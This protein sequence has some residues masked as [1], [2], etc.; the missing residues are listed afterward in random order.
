MP[1]VTSN[2]GGNYRWF[3]LNT[4]NQHAAYI[5]LPYNCAVTK[6]RIIA[7]G[8]NT[9]TVATRAAIWVPYGSTLGQS[10]TFDMADGSEGTQYTYE[11]S[12]TPVV[13]N[14][15]NY[16]VGLYRN[17]SESHIFRTATGS[18]DGYTKTNT[19]GFPSIWD[20]G[21]AGTDSNDEPT[22]GAFYI[23]TP[24]VAT[25]A[26]VTR[27]SDNNIVFGWYRNASSDKPVY[28]QHVERWDNITG[29]YYAKTTDNTTHLGGGWQT[30]T[31]VTVSGNKYY[32]YRVKAWN[33]AGYSSYLYS[34]YINTTPAAPSNVVAT[35]SGGNVNITW[36]DNATNEDQFR[37]QRRESTDEGASW[38]S[39]ADMSP[40]TV[41]AGT[42]LATDTSPYVYGQYRVRAEETSQ[43]LLS[44]YVE[45]NEVVTLAAPDAPS[46]LSPDDTPFD[47]SEEQNFTWN[48]N[49]TD[50]TA[51]TKFSLVVTKSGS[52]YPKEIC[53]FTDYTD[54]TSYN[55][56]LS[57]SEEHTLGL[58]NVTR[59]SDSN[60]TAGYTAMYKSIPSLD[61]THFDDSSASGTDDLIVFSFYMSD[62]SKATSLAVKLGDDNSNCYYTD[63]NPSVDLVDGYNRLEVAKSAFSTGGTPSGWDDIT[64]L[65]VE[66]YT[67]SGA[68]SSY[69]ESI[70]FML[71]D[72]ADFSDYAGDS[73]VQFNEI[74]NVS[75]A[76]AVVADS[77]INGIDYTYKVATWGE[78]ATGSGWS[79][80]ALF[81]CV[82]R[83]QGT[84]VTSE[85]YPYSQ[86]EVEWTY[87]QAE[88]YDQVQYLCKLYDSNDILLE[89]K[90]V[91]SIIADSETGS[92]LFETTLTN[93]TTYTITLQVQEANGLWSLETELEITTEFLQ[94]TQPS[95]SLQL[96]EMEGNVSISITN[97]EVVTE[98]QNQSTQDTY[99]D[100]DSSSTN[101][102]EIGYLIA[103][104]DTGGG[105][106]IRDILLDFN[107]DSFV[108][109]T[110]VD[111]QLIL[112][113]SVTLVAGIDTKVNYIKTSWDDANVTY[114][115]IPTLDTTDYDQH[116]HSAGDSE[117]WDITDLVT[118]IADGTITDFE[119]LAVIATTTDGSIDT[120]YDSTNDELEP[121]VLIEISPENA[122]TDHNIIYRS[123]NGGDWE[124]VAD[125]VPVD[126]T[127]IDYIPNIGG[128]N[129]YYA[130]SVSLVPSVNSS[131]EVDLDISLTGTFFINGG[132]NF[133]L[134]ARLIGDNK[135]NENIG[136]NEVLKQYKGRSYPVKYQDSSLS[137]VIEFSSDC[138]I[139]TRDTIEDIINNDGNIFYRDWRGRWFYA[140]IS[141]C[142][143]EPKDPAA[144]QFSCTITRLN[145]VIE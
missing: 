12:I 88:S 136:R 49:P 25:G 115:T 21:G 104:N 120:F 50:G 41:S 142:T 89:T 94:P 116:T 140:S 111:A 20:M 77:F 130:Q 119:G 65:R 127:V 30:F 36:T 105:T 96:N 70:Y 101:Y 3:G 15:G 122:E 128:N 32:R 40:A 67:T 4:N 44:S 137:Q 92:C 24:D 143:F 60:D 10:S 58:G 69:I 109:K 61:L 42:T 126:T 100:S 106:T 91:S 110:I 112:Y 78:Y 73:F 8:Y 99:I 138:L 34:N 68:S 6:L 64:Y 27:N 123:I 72:A 124:T 121:T 23:T 17:P 54:W 144:Y 74:S 97:P 59:M 80:E 83:P 84:I 87:T 93:T 98:Y 47:A 102:D 82:T 33:N 35:R 1:W 43:S 16:W 18:G 38:G 2:G 76:L 51:Q 53:N 14:A 13:L 22:V 90:Q 75:E 19:S 134:I 113:R 66:L 52:T 117:T 103:E 71:A 57:D 133:E 85:T 107:L 45:S 56:T 46:G 108:G 132:E 95:I 37:I 55:A 28:K 48:H 9:G 145:G 11:P 118:D 7:A 141:K 26:S 29:N 114:G 62:V 31:D 81:K 135:I 86:L 125:N 131:A 63:V 129:N 79:S 39:W 139:A 5:N